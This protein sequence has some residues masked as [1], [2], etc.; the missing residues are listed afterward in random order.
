MA[1]ERGREKGGK[2]GED[3]GREERCEGVR[4][5]GRCWSLERIVHT[6]ERNCPC[7]D[8]KVGELKL[9]S[10]FEALPRQP[11]QLEPSH[12][13]EIPIRPMLGE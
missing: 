8:A 4:E 2:G 1:S 13:I 3:E 11:I 12:P 5:G 7:V 9:S 10:R 6:N